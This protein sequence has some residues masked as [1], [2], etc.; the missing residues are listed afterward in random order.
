MPQPLKVA[1]LQMVSTPDVL[2]NLAAAGRLMAEAADAG[3]RLVALPEY[4]ACWAGATATS[5]ALP[6]PRAAARSRIFWPRRH[7]AWVCG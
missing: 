6:R 7:S 4:F 1:A 3:V 5:S 2:R